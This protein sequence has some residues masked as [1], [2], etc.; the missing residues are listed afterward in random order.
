MSEPMVNTVL[1]P[2]AASELGVTLVHEHVFV[3]LLREMRSDGWLGDGVVAVEELKRLRDAGGRTVVDTTNRG[4]GRQP[5]A[6]RAVSERTGLHIITGTGM[7][8][9]QYY[10]HDWVDR[11]SVGAIANWMTSEIDD[12]IE[13]TGVRAGIIG[14][15]GCDEYIT[16]HEERIFRASARAQQRTGVAISTHAARWPVGH[17]QLDLLEA[18]GADLRRVIVGHSDSVTSPTWFSRSDATDYHESLARRGPFVAFD[19]FG[20][21]ATPADDQRAMDYVVHLVKQ[22]FVSQVLVSQDI[23]FK[24]SLH[25]S[26]GNGYDYLLTVIVPKLR[27]RGIADDVLQTILVDN[28]RRALAGD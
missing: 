8:R 2:V 19:H 18:E 25:V 17:A 22:G 16:A 28:P 4:L 5:E 27:E 1:G 9:H 10:D 21:W 7:Y 14:E 3:N 12:G 15:I 24:S 13:G 20:G 26:G 11:N 23:C 6:L